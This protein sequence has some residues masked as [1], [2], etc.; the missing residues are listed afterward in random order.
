MI[1]VKAEV[2]NGVININPNTV[3][4][5]V[6][7]VLINHDVE[8]AWITIIFGGNEMLRGLKHEYFHQDVYT[9]VIS[10]RLHVE[11]EDLF[12]GEI[13]ISP[14][15]AK[16]NASEYGVSFENELCRLIVHGTLHLLGLE[17]TNS[18]QQ[19]EMRSLE[20]KYI[21]LMNYNK[22]IL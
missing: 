17:D 2:A 9:D 12:E 19:A 6:T 16:E 20:N 15:M 13:Y 14:Q 10:F 1:D 7:L 5:L 21:K 11:K 8:D 4:D 18:R 3:K 22:L